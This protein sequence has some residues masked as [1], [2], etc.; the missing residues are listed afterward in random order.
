MSLGSCYKKLYLGKVGAFAWC[1]VKILNYFR[2]LVWKAVHRTQTNIKAKTR[3]LYS[4]VFG[5]FLPN[6]IKID[7]Y[8]FELYSRFQA[9]AVFFW[10]T[11]YNQE[12]HI[13]RQTHTHGALHTVAICT[14]VRLRLW[15]KLM[16]EWPR[17]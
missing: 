6:V 11:V 4:R 10:D 8:N 17:N 7:P 9:G 14:I 16:H 15:Q 3:R 2:C 1:S 13:T 12:Q 5:I